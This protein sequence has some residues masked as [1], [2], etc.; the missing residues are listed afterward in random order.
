MLFFHWSYNSIL[1]EVCLPEMTFYVFDELCVVER[2][3]THAYAHTQWNKKLYS[4]SK[5]FSTTHFFDIG[6]YMGLFLP[7]GF[8]PLTLLF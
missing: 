6:V 1:K 4:I 3:R 8:S 2:N 7:Y 5:I